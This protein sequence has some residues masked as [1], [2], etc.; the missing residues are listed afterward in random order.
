M[1]LNKFNIVKCL[2]PCLSYGKHYMCVSYYYYHHYFIVTVI[3]VN[4]ASVNIH[5]ES[6]SKI[7]WTHQMLCTERVINKYLTEL[8]S[9]PYDLYG[10]AGPGGVCTTAIIS[11]VSLLVLGAFA[12]LLSHHLHNLSATSTPSVSQICSFFCHD[13]FCKNFTTL[14]N[15]SVSS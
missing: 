6:I 5:A 12:S 11:A 2:E 7:S 8:L 4:H 14:A 3:P 9:F 13:T 1:R 10:G 15:F